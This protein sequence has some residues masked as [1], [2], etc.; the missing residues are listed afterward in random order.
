MV[1]EDD[2]VRREHTPGPPSHAYCRILP[3][4]VHR[5]K[6]GLVQGKKQKGN[7]AQFVIQPGKKFWIRTDTGPEH[8]CNEDILLS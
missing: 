8:C 6:I 3:K 5:S 2:E 1:H 7:Y 4:S